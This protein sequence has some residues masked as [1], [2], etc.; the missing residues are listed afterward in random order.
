[1]DYSV[2]FS[3]EESSAVAYLLGVIERIR[4]GECIGVT[5]IESNSDGT[6]SS[7]AIL[8]NED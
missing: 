6:T 1:M 2:K 4:E 8:V 3:T 5:V 7:I